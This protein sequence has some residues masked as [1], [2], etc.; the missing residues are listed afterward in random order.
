MAKHL[1]SLNTGGRRAS[2][3]SRV[4]VF[5]PGPRAYLLSCSSVLEVTLCFRWSEEPAD[6]TE[7]E[8]SSS[9]AG[10][11]AVA[12]AAG[13][14]EDRGRTSMVSSSVDICMAP[15]PPGCGVTGGE[16]TMVQRCRMTSIGIV[17]ESQRLARS[18][19]MS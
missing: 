4:P 6:L 7:S 9:P 12:A 2:L 13:A 17:Y 10:A 14:V 15:L 1:L 19:V 16:V 8:S 18:H 3:P 11:G 5:T